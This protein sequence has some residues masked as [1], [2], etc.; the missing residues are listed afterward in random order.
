L[1]AL[2]IKLPIGL[3]EDQLEKYMEEIPRSIFDAITP[4]CMPQLSTRLIDKKIVLEIDVVRGAKKP[5]FLKSEGTPKG[6]YIRIQAQLFPKQ[7][8]FFPN[9]KV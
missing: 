1:S 6:V 7:K 8:Y 2:K 3:T 5:Y 9:L 4:Y